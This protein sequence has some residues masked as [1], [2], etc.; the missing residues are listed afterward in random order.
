MAILGV[1]FLIIAIAIVCLCVGGI[2]WSFIAEAEA[3][4]RREV[5]PP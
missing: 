3:A 2:V 4:R 1:I 5:F